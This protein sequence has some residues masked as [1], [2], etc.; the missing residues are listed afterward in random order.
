VE[1]KT[2]RVEVSSASGQQ[3]DFTVIEWNSGMFGAVYDQ[4]F[5]QAFHQMARIGPHRAGLGKWT[6]P[7]GELF[8]VEGRVPEAQFD[9]VLQALT[10]VNDESVPALWCGL[11][12]PLRISRGA[13]DICLSPGRIVVRPNWDSGSSGTIPSARDG[14]TSG[15][16]RIN[17]FRPN[18]NRLQRHEELKAIL[19]HELFHVAYAYHLCGGDLG[20]NP[21][22]FSV[23]N[24]PYPDSLMANLGLHVLRPSAQDMLASCL[25]YHPDTHLGNLLPDTNHSYQ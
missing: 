4:T 6:I 11:V 3:F 22:G 24:C 16:I 23:T 13:C 8:L 12:G 9:S 21:F 2:L 25:V 5:H 19:V 7:P 10:E 20:Q 1:H 17:V 18:D 15:D 14:A